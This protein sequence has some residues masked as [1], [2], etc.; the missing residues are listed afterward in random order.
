MRKRYNDTRNNNIGNYFTQ[1]I[2]RKYIL[3]SLVVL[4]FVFMCILLSIERLSNTLSEYS[5]FGFLYLLCINVLVT[6]ASVSIYHTI[7]TCFFGY[8]Q[9]SERKYTVLQLTCLEK[10]QTLLRSYCK[11]SDNKLYTLYDKRQYDE[12]TIGKPCDLVIISNEYG[13]K[14]WEIVVSNNNSTK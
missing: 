1:L 7:K 9:L 13:A 3:P 12:I 11:L 5:T 10:K 4:T 8:K 6:I 14:L 2:I